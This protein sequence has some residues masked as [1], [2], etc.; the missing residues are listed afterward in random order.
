MVDY[1]T[2][3]GA[4][5]IRVLAARDREE[6]ESKE[7]TDTLASAKGIWFGGGRQWRFVDAYAGT[8]AVELFQDVLKRGG[9]IGGSSAGASIQAEF[10]CRGNPMGNEEIVCEGYD[11][12]LGFL[13][14]VAIDQHFTQRNR[15][16][17][18]LNLVK[19]YPQFLGI[20]LDEATAIVVRGTK[21]EVLGKHQAH[22]Y[23]AR[24]MEEA[25]NH[26]ALSAG[27]AFDLKH[28]RITDDKPTLAVGN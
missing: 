15:F 4:K 10:L 21:A 25:P 18:M 23:D 24:P 13:R 22:F 5:N 2:K 7:F 17:D 11:R 26:V 14:G 8:K 3:L 9:V 27:Q 12:G 28:R 19:T 1:L 20:G 6:V 16:Q